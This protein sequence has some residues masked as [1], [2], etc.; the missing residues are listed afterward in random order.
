MNEIRLPQMA[1]KRRSLIDKSS[2]QLSG[3]R[4]LSGPSAAGNGASRQQLEVKTSFAWM[5]HAVALRGGIATRRST[6]GI[7]RRRLRGGEM[8]RRCC[9]QRVLRS[10]SPQIDGESSA[11]TEFSR[12]IGM[13]R[14]F[15]SARSRSPIR[16]AFTAIPRRSH[17]A[18]ASEQGAR[19]C[20]EAGAGVGGGDRYLKKKSHARCKA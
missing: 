19:E 4:K 18:L 13:A 7:R 16:V 12:P 6:G 14:G 8:W 9:G 11:R 20:E 3:K 15:G 2:P 10:M 17:A 1:H 5:V